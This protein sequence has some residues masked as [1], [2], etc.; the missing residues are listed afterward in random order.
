MTRLA[1]TTGRAGM[2]LGDKSASLFGAHAWAARG[3]RASLETALA[4]AKEEGN[5]FIIQSGRK[6]GSGERLR[7]RDRQNTL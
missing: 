1:R 6:K 7:K 4:A 3:Q 5:L 2:N